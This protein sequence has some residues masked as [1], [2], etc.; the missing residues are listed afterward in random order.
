MRL[1]LFDQTKYTKWYVRE[2]GAIL[3]SSSYRNNYQLRIIKPNTNKA[4]GYLYARTTNGNFQIHRL[5]ASAFID[6]ADNKPY[7]NHIDFDR[8]NNNVNNLEWVTAKEN[9]QHS[10]LNGRA[11]LMK[12]N[13]GN[14]K[15]TEEQCRTVIARVKSGMTYVKAGVLYNMPY[16]TVAHLV[17]GSRRYYED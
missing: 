10:I 3:S 17:R 5:V 16:S 11:F 6:N 1:A 15:Y 4:R 8:H 7:V 14:L 12:K 9:T 13:E 2:D